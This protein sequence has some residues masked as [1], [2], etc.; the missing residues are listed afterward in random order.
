M[1]RIATCACFALPLFLAACAYNLPYHP[2]NR[3]EQIE[4]KK[5]LLD[6]YPD[7]VRTN[8]AQHTNSLVAWAGIIRETTTD[9]ADD[10]TIRAVTTFEHHYFDW[11]ED[12]E[13]V[14]PK[15]LVSPKGEGM[16]KTEWH[17]RKKTPEAT[18]TD[19]G[20]FASPGKLAIVYGF[21]ETLEDKTVVLHY[22]Y[23]RVIGQS[24]YCTNEFEYG[25][26]GE[27]F[28]Y[29]GKLAK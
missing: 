21:P 23:L 3:P 11:Q 18:T 28:K 22:R 20:K 25:R 24:S 14:S 9:D 7:D 17:L 15:L 5:A 4:N 1:N 16:F 10:G 12:R 19:A 6:V 13:V 29:L 27:P 26:F 8:L 2:V